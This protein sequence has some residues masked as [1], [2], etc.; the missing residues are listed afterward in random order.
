MWW[1]KILHVY[2][3]DCIR[4]G[5]DITISFVVTL[6]WI[7]LRC[8]W[9]NC[10][11]VIYDRRT[12][13]YD[14]TMIVITWTR[15]KSYDSCAISYYVGRRRTT[16]AQQREKAVHVRTC[17]KYGANNVEGKLWKC[18]LITVLQRNPGKLH[19]RFH[20]VAAKRCMKTSPKHYVNIHFWLK[21]VLD[22]DLYLF[23]Y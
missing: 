9:D 5:Y 7:G 20:N 1:G 21:T 17:G 19:E 4:F 16:M 18:C 12:R 8:I 10:R 15:F 14:F 6:E 22:F 11:Q 2:I 3:N 13:S 23:I